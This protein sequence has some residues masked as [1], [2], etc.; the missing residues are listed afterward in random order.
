M[1]VRI[2]ITTQYGQAWHC[3]SALVIPKLKHARPSR[4]NAS[5]LLPKSLGTRRCCRTSDLATRK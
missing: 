5:G 2:A 3:T 1:R 4:C